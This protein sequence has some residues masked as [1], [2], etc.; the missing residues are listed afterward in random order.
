MP[1]VSVIVNIW[2]GAA[3]LRDA[4]DSVLAQGFA[5]WELVAW[6]DRSSDGS[7]A[8]VAEYEDPRI[9]YFL[10]PEPTWLGAARQNAIRQASGEWLAF[11]DQ[12][13]VWLPDKLER[14]MPLAAGDVGMIY[15]RTLMFRP[16]GGRLRDYDYAHEFVPLPEGDIFQQ[17]FSQ[18]CFIAMSSALM[19]RSAVEE[20][21][22]IPANLD[23]I[24]DHFLYA[25]IAR[26]YQ[27]R[28]TQAVVCRYRVHAA[29]MS[30]QNLGRMY[31]EELWMLDHFQQDLEPATFAYRRMTY[32]S[33]LA[34]VEMNHRDT[35]ARGRKRL[36]RDGSWLWLAGRPLV[37]GWRALRRLVRTPYWQRV[38]S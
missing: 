38:P 3:T 20:V 10:S 32:S 2:N 18:A 5:D 28:C 34:L 31:E 23:I 26:R 7:A 33:A 29:N 9:R 37:R 35:A 8:I 11:L 25:A 24:P 15:G 19:R 21:G 30:R 6:D 13:D 14:Q 4:L 36:L 1:K 12:D 27:V 16:S 22:G 17:L